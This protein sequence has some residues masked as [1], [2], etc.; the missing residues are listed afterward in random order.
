MREKLD[1]V[2][3]ESLEKVLKAESVYWSE[4]EEK[5]S[6][7]I[8]SVLNKRYDEFTKWHALKTIGIS[9]KMLFCLPL[10]DKMRLGYTIKYEIIDLNLEIFFSFKTFKWEIS[11]PSPDIIIQG[12]VSQLSK[13]SFYI[14]YF[15]LIPF[16]ILILDVLRGNVQVQGKRKIF[17]LLVWEG[18][19][20]KGLLKS[21]LGC[22]IR[23][24]VEGFPKDS[25][26]KNT[27]NQFNERKKEVFILDAGSGTGAT[28]KKCKKMGFKVL[29]VDISL[30]QLNEIKDPGIFKLVADLINPPFKDSAKFDVIFLLEV[31]E[32]FERKWGEKLIGSL[33]KHLRKDGLMVVSTPNPD[34]PRQRIIR[35]LERISR[36]TSII[37]TFHPKEYCV[38]DLKNLLESNEL[39]IKEAI[40]Q[41]DLDVPF[42]IFLKPFKNVSKFLVN[43]FPSLSYDYVIICE[44]VR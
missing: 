19:W 6:K 11:L 44:K 43:R 24:A 35:K 36:G 40:G 22:D 13:R 38:S 27:L 37:W 7:E 12:K 42:A 9:P 41:R 15:G 23:L 29:A 17:K 32:H 31:I 10:K 20:F 8:F 34:T 3:S 25:L 5:T 4:L 18:G 1:Y 28:A 16:F 26:I 2:Y 30:H 14:K 21:I 39:R 33:S